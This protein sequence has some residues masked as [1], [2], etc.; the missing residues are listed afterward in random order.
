VHCK[1]HKEHCK[2]FSKKRES[3]MVTVY[4]RAF[5]RWIMECVRLA[6]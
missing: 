2:E 6:S 5:R 3:P 1:Q 4:I